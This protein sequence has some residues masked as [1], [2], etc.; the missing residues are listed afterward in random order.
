MNL[1]ELKSFLNWRT[2]HDAVNSATACAMLGI[3]RPA[4]ITMRER[5]DIKGELWDGEWWYP[6]K[7]VDKNKIKPGEVRRGRP[8]SGLDRRQTA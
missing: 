8:R 5:G 3:S 2:K 4:I 7:E 6:R 1:K